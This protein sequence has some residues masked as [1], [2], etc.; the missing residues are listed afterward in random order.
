MYVRRACVRGRERTCV[1]TRMTRLRLRDAT[2]RIYQ[3]Y[4]LQLIYYGTPRR[5][6]ARRNI[7]RCLTLC[8][9]Y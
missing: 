4:F 9:L 5:G 3:Y 6:A 1:Y 7:W 8:R 2:L